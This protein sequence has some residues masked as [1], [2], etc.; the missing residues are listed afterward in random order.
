VRALARA[1]ASSWHAA[2]AAVFPKER[3][4][5]QEQ[6]SALTVQ[7]EWDGGTALLTVQGEIDTCTAE[8]LSG[9]LRDVIRKKPDRLIID[10]AGVSF[11]DCSAVHAFIE[12]RR[13]L[14]LE[15]PLILRSPRSQARRVFELTAL[16]SVFIAD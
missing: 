4:L 5:A 1:P 8:V 6:N 14:S 16:D 7:D 15:Y 13:A 2:Y 3:R 12:A 11:L 10:L 9:C